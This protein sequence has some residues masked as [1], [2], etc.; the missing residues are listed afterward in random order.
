LTSA[1]KDEQLRHYLQKH[2]NEIDKL[3]RF[4]CVTPLLVASRSRHLNTVKLLLELGANVD[5]TSKFN[6]TALMMACLSSHP[7]STEIVKVLLSWNANPNHKNEARQQ[8]LHYASQCG[9]ADVISI[10]LR[11][12]GIEY[13][14]PDDEGRTPLSC[15][16]ARGYVTVVELLCEKGA[17]INIRDKLG[18]SPLSCACVRGY[19]T[20]VELLCEKGANINIRDKLG[21]SPLSCACAKGHINIV[22]LLCEKGAS[23]NACDENGRTP[24]DEAVLLEHFE[25]I[26]F[27]R[28]KGAKQKWAL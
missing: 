1:G 2:P 4:Q 28:T 8:P 26:A 22:R 6:Q 25:L 18:R 27:L 7:V 23:I 13:D 19:V 3:D 21:R 14:E 24:L 15:A 20:V 17:K 10:F 12:N 5:G 9:A 16:C 11:L